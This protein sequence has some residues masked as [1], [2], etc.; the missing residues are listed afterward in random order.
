MNLNNF[1]ILYYRNEYEHSLIL[2]GHQILPL[3]FNKSR[4]PFTLRPT[5]NPPEALRHPDNKEWLNQEKIASML[6]DNQIV[7]ILVIFNYFKQLIN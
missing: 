6:K 3:F 1:I 4:F 5:A 7:N 2:A